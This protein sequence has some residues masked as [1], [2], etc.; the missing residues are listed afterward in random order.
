VSART[1]G[2]ASEDASLSEIEARSLTDDGLRGVEVTVTAETNAGVNVGAHVQKDAHVQR[3]YELLVENLPLGVLSIAPDGS[4]LQANRAALSILDLPSIDSAQ[5]TNLFNAAPLVEAGID[6]DLRQCIESGERVISE[7]PFIGEHDKRVYLRLS[8]NPLH[9]HRERVTSV[10]GLI[11]DITEQKLT[12]RALHEVQRQFEDQRLELGKLS[13]AIEHSAN[14]V[15]ITDLDARI[16]YVNPK[17]VELTGY[18]VQEAL[19]QNPSMLKSGE[20][21]AEYYKELWQ[22]ITAGKQWTGEFHNRRKDGTLYWELA[23]IAPIFD[24]AGQMTHF[25]G[26]KEDITKR[27]EAEVQ[28]QLITE[29]LQILH[30]I[31]QSVLAAQLPETIAIAAIHRIR[32]LIPCERV[33]VVALEGKGEDDEPEDGEAKE[34]LEGS[35]QGESGEKITIL[36]SVSSGEIA[37]VSDPG[38]Y[39]EFFQ[40]HPLGR[41]LV[42]G[43][44]DLAALPQRS[45]LQQFLF[46]AGMRSYLAVPLFIQD[47]L[48]GTLNL[49]STRARA[50]TPD[51]ITIAIELAA[52]LAVAIRQ[53]R[54]Y[55]RAQQEITERMQAESTLR[56]SN[57][58]L[59][60]RNAELDA[61]AHTVAHDLKNPVTSIVGYADVL[62]KNRE[63]LPDDMQDQ[64]LLVIG[65][66]SHKLASIIDELLL[67]AS[68]RG[69]EEIELHPLEMGRIVAEARG[70]LLHLIEEHRGEIS[71]PETWPVAL[72]YAPWVEAIWTNYISNALKYGGRTPRVELGSSADEG[73]WVRFWVRDNGPGLSPQEQAR[74]FTPFERLHQRRAEGH[75]LGL[76]IV[77]RIVAKLGGQ[78][79]VE[80]DGLPGQGCTFYFTLPALATRSNGDHD[81]V[82]TDILV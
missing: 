8:L 4:I 65:R 54:L 27:K 9:D 80:S 79:G 66:N 38:V 6:S 21:S 47:E 25:I 42:Q 73:G 59:E 2:S 40:Q 72:G 58:E 12:E 7:R 70:R 44:E 60:A 76:S 26:I 46:E 75:G 37:S 39:M 41:G 15:M 31:D 81:K 62:S 52:S 19:G 69:K 53:A 61:F 22:T 45:I 3:E 28:L 30:E 1:S 14:V 32:H 48:V 36:A 24:S 57:R 23:S 16:E 10:Q 77:Q 56:I 29:R 18:S 78:V 68:V 55:E 63:T 67:L 5:E 17:F 33:L 34:G 51:H 35:R 20:Q 49:E 82:E 11:E 13:H 50:F 43:T 71:L 64:F 74:L